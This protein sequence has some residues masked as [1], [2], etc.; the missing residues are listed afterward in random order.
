MFAA[1]RQLDPFI[2]SSACPYSCGLIEFAVRLGGTI[3]S[4][5]LE[6]C[7]IIDF[8]SSEKDRCIKTNSIEL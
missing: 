1:H 7:Q 8:K 3:D 5:F 6:Q 4:E 2:L